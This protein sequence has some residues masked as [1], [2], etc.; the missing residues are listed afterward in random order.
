MINLNNA[1][2]QPW[3]LIKIVPSVPIFYALFQ[4]DATLKYLCHKII[5]NGHEQLGTTCILISELELYCGVSHSTSKVKLRRLR[6]WMFV[7]TFKVNTGEFHASPPYLHSLFQLKYDFIFS[8][9]KW[10]WAVSTYELCSMS[11]GTGPST[12]DLGHSQDLSISDM[13]SHTWNY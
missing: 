2:R 10:L 4:A 5:R 7:R 3:A 6:C 8:L 11:V 1:H 12:V 13:F 9:T